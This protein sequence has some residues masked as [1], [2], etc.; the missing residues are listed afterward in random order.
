MRKG[1][2][3]A[4]AML[5][6]T[7]CTEPSG[8]F[9]LSHFKTCRLQIKPIHQLTRP[10]LNEQFCFAVLSLTGTFME[11]EE[12]ARLTRWMTQ[13]KH[14]R[15]SYYFFAKQSRQKSRRYRKREEARPGERWWIISRELWQPQSILCRGLWV[16]IRRTK[17]TSL[18]A[19]NVNGLFGLV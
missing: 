18:V 1:F 10:F 14:F 3:Q 12:L 4:E 2:E 7:W 19:I 11:I 17:K 13:V 16:V 9:W 5:S 15:C 6:R 8:L